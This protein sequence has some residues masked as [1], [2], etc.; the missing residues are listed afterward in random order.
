MLQWQHS[1]SDWTALHDA[2]WFHPIGLDHP[3]SGTNHKHTV[4]NIFRAPWHTSLRWSGLS[5]L[6]QVLYA[7]SLSL[8]IM[9]RHAPHYQRASQ[10]SYRAG[11]ITILAP[12]SPI[13]MVVVRQ[14]A[15][16]TRPLLSQL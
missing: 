4:L 10:L 7:V 9:V 11:A 1:T 6:I 5:Y 14:V 3:V 15:Y 12:L 16:N 13:E 2:F 8:A